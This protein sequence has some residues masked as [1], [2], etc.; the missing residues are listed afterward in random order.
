MKIKIYAGNI[1]I[2]EY[3]HT[4]I[5]FSFCTVNFKISFGTN[6]ILKTIHIIYPE[7]IIQTFTWGVAE[8][9]Y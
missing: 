3:R 7:I 5:A 4:K 8:I 6:N 2:P 9:A 1:Y